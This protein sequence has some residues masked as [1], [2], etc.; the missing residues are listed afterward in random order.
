MF[1]RWLTA[2]LLV[3]V[4]A[5]LAEPAKVVSLIP[6][7]GAVNVT[8]GLTN[9]V[10]EFDQDMRSGFSVTG[11]GPTFPRITGKLQ[12]ATPRRLIV[13]VELRPGHDY[14]FG[15]NSRSARNFR[16]LAGEPTEPVLVTFRTEGQAGTALTNAPAMAAEL[17]RVIREHYS[18]RD[19]LVS[20]WD[21][22]LATAWP[23]L[24]NAVTDVAFAA[25]TVKLLAA[26]DDPH[27]TV[28]VE[29]QRL[30][31]TTRTLRPNAD[32]RRLA[33]L[34]PGWREANR[35]VATGRF[36]DGLGYLLISTWGG[37]D[38][39]VAPALTALDEWKVAGARGVIVDVRFNGGGD[40]Q[41][42][43]SVAGRFTTTNVVYAR[44]R[45]RDPAEPGGWSPVRNRVLRGEANAT[46]HF[47]GKVAVLMGPKCM[48]SNEA[49]LLMMRATGARLFG[50]RS[51]GSS[52]NPKRFDLGGGVALSVPSWEAQDAA[53]NGIEGRGIAPDQ[54]VAF[55]ASAT[56]DAVLDA[57]LTWLRE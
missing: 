36:P 4:F 39:D 48:S 20:D 42:A 28:L 31:T 16:N 52:G 37:S 38:A 56:K 54:T 18:Y 5:A 2:V 9:L 41:Q 1:S 40:E 7:N 10:I 23:G 49:F 47:T 8:V 17:Q 33:Q 15:I 53:G 51:A 6:T 50:E 30:G 25:E 13:P 55:K 24:S 29:G 12:W 22:R 46:R 26:A 21:A 35:T 34:V 43:R 27:L 44:H 57:A 19:R 11:G 45:T 3:P 14:R 32:F